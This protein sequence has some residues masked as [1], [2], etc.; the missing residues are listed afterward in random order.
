MMNYYLDTFKYLNDKH[1]ILYF[2]IK[3]KILIAKIE[4]VKGLKTIKNFT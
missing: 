1:L 2:I 4:V 3:I